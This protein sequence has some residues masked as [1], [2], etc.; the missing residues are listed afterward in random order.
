MRHDDCMESKQHLAEGPH[1]ESSSSASGM[2]AV[3]ALLLLVVLLVILAS[4]GAFSPDGGGIDIRL[5]R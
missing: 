2:I 3:T 4:N 5:G 1:M